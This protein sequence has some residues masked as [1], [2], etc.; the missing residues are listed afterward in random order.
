MRTEWHG[1]EYDCEYEEHICE[2]FL[3]ALNKLYLNKPYVVDFY[4]EDVVMLSVT[5]D[6][7]NMSSRC[8][9]YRKDNSA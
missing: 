1:F 2:L 4:R 6:I 8:V 7:T 3:I 9:R 5:H